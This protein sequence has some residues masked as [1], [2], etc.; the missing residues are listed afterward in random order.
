MNY[1]GKVIDGAVVLEEGSELPEGTLVEVMPLGN[2]RHKHHP[3]VE[4]IAG[5]L[6]Q[7]IEL[8]NDYVHH[9]IEK[10]R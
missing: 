7:D 8:K 9:I 5:I 10:H 2:S 6:P 1:R 4:R 3:D